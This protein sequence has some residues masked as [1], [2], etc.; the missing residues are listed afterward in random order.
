VIQPSSGDDA[1][2]VINLHPT[3][4]LANEV[5]VEREVPVRFGGDLVESAGVHTGKKKRKE[6][7]KTYVDGDGEE[8]FDGGAMVSSGADAITF[9]DPT[10]NPLVNSC[11]PSLLLTPA[12][13]LLPSS[14]PLPPVHTKYSHPRH[15]R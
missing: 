4:I 9:Q 5:V 3:E 12:T 10:P 8:D 13:S 14:L 2:S 1:I 6:G 15:N 7:K 11:T